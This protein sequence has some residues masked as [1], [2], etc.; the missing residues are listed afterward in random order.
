MAPTGHLLGPATAAAVG[1]RGS[2]G[3]DEATAVCFRLPLGCGVCH[4]C[5]RSAGQDRFPGRP[6]QRQQVEIVSYLAGS[7]ARESRVQVLVDEQG[8]PPP[9]GADVLAGKGL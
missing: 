1:D 7:M 9:E 5:S 6:A 3:A 4:V 2:R 8:V